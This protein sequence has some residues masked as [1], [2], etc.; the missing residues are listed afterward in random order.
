MTGSFLRVMIEEYQK[1]AEKKSR[2][3]N[4]V[5]RRFHQITA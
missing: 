5:R 2:R 1:S 4:F 3:T